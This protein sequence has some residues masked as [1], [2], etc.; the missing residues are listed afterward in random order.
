MNIY[1]IFSY[2]VLTVLSYQIVHFS[3][4]KGI[5]HYTLLLCY[6]TNNNTNNKS[7]SSSLHHVMLDTQFNHTVYPQHYPNTKCTPT[8]LTLSLSS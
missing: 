6:H 3:T 1:G 5:F 8:I 4:N 7:Q 2:T